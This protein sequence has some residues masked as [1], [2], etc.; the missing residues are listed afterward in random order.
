MLYHPPLQEDTAWRDASDESWA[1]Y[2]AAV[3]AAAVERGERDT[4]P[5]A[6]G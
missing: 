5:Q 3:Y 4:A 1:R 6:V 2:A